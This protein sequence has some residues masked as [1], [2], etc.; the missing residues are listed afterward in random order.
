MSHSIEHMGLGRGFWVLLLPAILNTGPKA[1]R[2][3]VTLID[4][5]KCAFAFQTRCQQGLEL[6]SAWWRDNA[7]LL[8]GR[9][10]M[11]GPCCPRELLLR[12]VELHSLNKRLCLIPVQEGRAPC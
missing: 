5:L 11:K 6:R 9:V 10:M 3:K 8:I 7:W 12:V 1:A 2:S 4:S